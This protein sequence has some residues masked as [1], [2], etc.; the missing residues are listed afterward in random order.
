[1]ALFAL[2]HFVAALVTGAIAQGL[3]FDQLR[4]RSIVSRTAG[5]VHDVLMAPHTA[6][7]RAMPNRWLTQGRVPVIP[8]LLLGHSAV[9]GIALAG[10]VS[11][12]Q[13]AR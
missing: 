9:W 11:R 2:L 1:M 4:S 8:L 13:M 5:V 12:G 7:I 3:D 6:V 10:V